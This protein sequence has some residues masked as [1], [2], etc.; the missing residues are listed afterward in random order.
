MAATKKVAS[1][2]MSAGT[3]E[4]IKLQEAKIEVQRRGKRGKPLLLLHS[5]DNYETTRPFVD[6]LAK[7]ATAAR[8]T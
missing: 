3:R 6:E 7:D 4:F 5:E 2:T 8:N 1:P